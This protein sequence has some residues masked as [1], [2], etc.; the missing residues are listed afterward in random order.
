MAQQAHG[1]RGMRQRGRRHPSQRCGIANPK[2]Y[3]H[4]ELKIIQMRMRALLQLHRSRLESWTRDILLTRPSAS[5][6]I[7]SKVV[8]QSGL[9]RLEHFVRLLKRM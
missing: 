4:G 6:C 1:T 7:S 2:F 3:E 9:P 8:H 5:F